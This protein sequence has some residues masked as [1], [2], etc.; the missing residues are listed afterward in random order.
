MS[1]TSHSGL[2]KKRRKRA[3]SVDSSTRDLFTFSP[4]QIPVTYR[5][6][7]LKLNDLTAA[8]TLVSYEAS[9]ARQNSLF[10]P[11]TLHPAGTAT[12]TSESL[13]IKTQRSHSSQGFYT[14]TKGPEKPSLS[15]VLSSEIEESCLFHLVSPRSAGKRVHFQHKFG[16]STSSS[17]PFKD[18]FDVIEAFAMGK[19][20][21]ESEPMYLNYSNSTPW[22]PYSLVVVPKMHA[23]PEHF[24]ISKF[25]ILHIYPDGDCDLQNFAEWLQE[26][27]LFTMLR[28]IPF[29]RLCILRKSFSHWRR[30]VRYNQFLRVHNQVIKTSLRFFPSFSD[31]ILKIQ[32]LNEE[33]LSVPFHTLL[34][35]G[36]YSQE[37]FE[38]KLES[39]QAKLEKFLQRYFKYCRRIVAEVIESTQ[40]HAL[41]LE[42]EKRHQPFVS[43]LPLSIQKEKHAKLERDLEVAQ[44]RVTRLSNFVTL[45]DNLVMICLLKLARQ[46]VESWIRT[47]LKQ[48]SDATSISGH[49][50]VDRNDPQRKTMT[51]VSEISSESDREAESR[52]GARTQ[53]SEQGT[54]LLLAELRFGEAGML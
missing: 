41:K 45:A 46:S 53:C 21:T 37:A 12:R 36:G 38:Q 5:G 14:P 29:F 33:L 7:P 11:A 31:G 20:H 4:S 35:L 42:M 30:N 18:A 54:A 13:A 8:A 34:P 6:P 39:S 1:K 51:P 50:P 24:V 15:P 27:S 10:P 3:A 9:T 44:Y 32:N 28:K 48:E 23:S 25:G 52:S 49:N 16:Q 2:K 47:T 17:G 26:A 22:N 43:E 19:L 40:S